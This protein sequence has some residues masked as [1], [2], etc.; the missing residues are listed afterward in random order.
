MLLL[1]GFFFNYISTNLSTDKSP[2]TKIRH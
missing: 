2:C 1:K